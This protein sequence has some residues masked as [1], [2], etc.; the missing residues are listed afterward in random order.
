MKPA[1]QY[2]EENFQMTN[3]D[4]RQED[5][6]ALIRA[7]QKDA[8]TT[9][10]ASKPVDDLNIGIQNILK[11][12]EDAYYPRGSLTLPST[13]HFIEQAFRAGQSYLEQPNLGYDTKNE[14]DLFD[15]LMEVLPMSELNANS[16][17]KDVYKLLTL[18]S[19]QRIR[20][21]HLIQAQRAT[22]ESDAAM[23]GKQ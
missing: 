9:Y 7:V 23:K 4:T 5:F 8:I 12:A 17:E 13:R 10:N 22:L 11:A 19:Q 1:E 21:G 20:I 3:I 14:D 18:C 6:I 16:F 2:Y 15:R